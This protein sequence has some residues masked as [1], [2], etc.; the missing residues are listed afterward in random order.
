[1]KIWTPTSDGEVYQ[2]SAA[3]CVQLLHKYWPGH[4]M[5]DV[6]HFDCRP[7]IEDT[8]DPAS[9]VRCVYL[10]PSMP[11]VAAML[12][13]LT[14]HNRD[15]LVLLFLDDYGV[16]QPVDVARVEAAQRIMAADESIASFALTWQ[17]CKHKTD[18]A[19]AEGV[20]QFGRWDY[21]VN[22]QAGIWRRGDLVEILQGIPADIN[23]WEMEVAA[24]RYFAKAM[25]P[26]PREKKMV[27]WDIPK[28]ANAGPFVDG[29]DKSGWIISYANLVHQRRRDQRHDA[30][31]RQE[32][33][34]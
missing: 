22:T 3:A 12:E 13:Y 7:A 33:L 21:W 10:G 24:S 23:V 32:G 18:Y 9:L 25:A 27:G 28:P 30:F 34:L 8:A 5:I 15:D 20:C 31:L 29:T 17:P 6:A 16:Q 14:K 26:A 4:P 19:N 2:W 11:W 1:M